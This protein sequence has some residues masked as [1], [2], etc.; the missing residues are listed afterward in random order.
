MR[1]S[2]VA[3]VLPICDRDAAGHPSRE[4]VHARRTDCAHDPPSQWKTLMH[5][6]ST[7]CLGDGL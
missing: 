3:E 1:D 7:L 2:I 5:R 4:P 6:K